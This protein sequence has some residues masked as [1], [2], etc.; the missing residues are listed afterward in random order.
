MTAQELDDHVLALQ[1]S[2]SGILGPVDG[3]WLARLAVAT[4]ALLTAG[5]L[6]RLLRRPGPKGASEPLLDSP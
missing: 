3:P 4:A 6:S 5:L 2:G 1:D